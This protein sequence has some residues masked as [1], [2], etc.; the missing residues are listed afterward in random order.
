MGEQV[1]ITM[2]GEEEQAIKA[3]Q[4][5]INRWPESLELFGWSGT[6]TVIKT[7]NVTGRRAAVQ[8]I[9]GVNCDGGDPDEATI[10]QGAK[11]T[12]PSNQ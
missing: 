5:L 10:T 11:V 6:L 1:R 2:T 7:D 9:Y 8:S 3:L 4:R 12:W